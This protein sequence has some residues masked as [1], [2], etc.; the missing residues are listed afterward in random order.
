[1]I[2]LLGDFITFWCALLARAF[3]SHGF[4]MDVSCWWEYAV[5]LDVFENVLML[6]ALHS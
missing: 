3:N 5:N 1:M 4:Q 2:N 6:A